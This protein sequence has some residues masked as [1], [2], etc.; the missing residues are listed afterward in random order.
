MQYFDVDWLCVCCVLI[1][2]GEIQIVCGVFNV[3]VGIIVVLVKFGDYVFGF[4]VMLGVGKICGVES[5]GMMVLEW[6]LELLDEY[7]GI[8][9]LFLGEVGD[10][11]VDWLVVNCFEVVDLVIEIKIIFNC[12]DV[13]GVCGVVCDL[14]VCGFG[15]L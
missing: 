9:E 6:E 15:M 10:L 14:V 12:F 13:F 2:Y 8:I 3:C 4:D 5:F 1:D 11:F 7:N